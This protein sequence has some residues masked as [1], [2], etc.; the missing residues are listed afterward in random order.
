[1]REAA[2]ARYDL[3]VQEAVRRDHNPERLTSINPGLS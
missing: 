1:M 2:R 3:D